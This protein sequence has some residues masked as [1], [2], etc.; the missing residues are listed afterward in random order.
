MG[1]VGALEVEVGSSSLLVSEH[2]DAPPSARG[3][4][5]GGKGACLGL[6]V[7]VGRATLAHHASSCKELQCI[8]EHDMRSFK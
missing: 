5:W 2:A 8:K 1:A 6:R 3:W 7:C 4:K